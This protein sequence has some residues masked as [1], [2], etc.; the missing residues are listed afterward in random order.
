[1]FIQHGMGRNTSTNNDPH[2]PGIVG[3]HHIPVQSDRTNALCD[4]PK[5][6]IATTVTQLESKQVADA[7]WMIRFC[8]LEN[9]K[10]ILPNQFCYQ[11]YLFVILY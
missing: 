7:I 8:R 5:R 4:R 9:G 10:Y 3:N 11:T 1:M 6:C 2:G